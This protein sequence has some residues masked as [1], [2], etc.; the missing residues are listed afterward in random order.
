MILRHRTTRYCKQ[1]H[2]IFRW[3]A[4]VGD[5]EE[6]VAMSQ[7]TTVASASGSTR[8][9]PGTGSAEMLTAERPFAACGKLALMYREP[10]P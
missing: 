7:W 10:R 8:P 5:W 1:R 9:T 3:K 2:R 6:R 4:V